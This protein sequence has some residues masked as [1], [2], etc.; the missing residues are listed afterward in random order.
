MTIGVFFGG[1][2]PE[3]DISIITGNLIINGLHK[4]GITAHAIY[5]GKDGSWHIGD[6]LK[7]IAHFKN[8]KIFP[9]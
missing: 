1:K 3:H 5:I 9:P 7:D 8:K 6:E 2:N 4:A